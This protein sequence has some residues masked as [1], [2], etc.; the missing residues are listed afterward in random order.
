[1]YNGHMDIQR[2][3]VGIAIIIERNNKV[4]LGKRKGSH[5]SGSWAF[6]GGHLEFN[7]SLE[8]CAT[9]E[10]MEET[11]LTINN[12]RKYTFTNDIMKEENKHYITCYL[13]ADCDTGEPKIM[14][15]NKCEEWN[16]FGWN[17]LPSPLFIP[18]Q[19]LLKEL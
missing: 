12:I 11:G 9:R 19:N 4:L 7:E 8:D 2:P 17:E 5:G 15:P 1:L 18:L 6:P 13:K 3:K 16:W 14:E 10:V